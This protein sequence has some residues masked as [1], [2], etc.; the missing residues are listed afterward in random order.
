LVRQGVSPESDEYFNRIDKRMR[1]VF[2][3]RFEDSSSSQTKV[4]DIT[5]QGTVVAPATRSN[6]AASAPRRI[7]LTATQVS[8]ARTL[9]IST[10]QYARQLLKESS[11][12]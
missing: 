1:E 11:N 3:S 12:V 5:Q 7:T 2:P 4:A 6:G 9:G 8:L 10:E